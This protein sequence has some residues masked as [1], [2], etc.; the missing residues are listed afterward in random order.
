[1]LCA[2]LIPARTAYRSGVTSGTVSLL[3][4]ASWGGRTNIIAGISATFS[5]GSLHAME[6]GAILQKSTA[7]HVAIHRPDPFSTKSQ[8]SVSSQ[9]AGLRRLLYGWENQGTETGKWFRKA[10]EVQHHSPDSLITSQV[11]LGSSAS[12]H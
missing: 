10:A 11:S 2:S 5:T 7:L 4:P 1:M 6:K 8:V 3:K 9:V 12:S